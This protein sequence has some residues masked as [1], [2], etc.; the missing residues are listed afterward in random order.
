MATRKRTGAEYDAPYFARAAAGEDIHGEANLITTLLREHFPTR[1]DTAP[2]T[3]QIL[4]A[5]CGTGRTGIELA[6]RGYEVVGVDLDAVMLDQARAKAPNL[7]WHQAD[8]ATV[9]LAER[10]DCIV[11]AGNVM[12][13][14][15][16]G[17]EATVL[18]NLCSQ[19]KP[20]GLVVAGF[21]SRP[22]TWSQL[23]PQRYVDIAA[24][25]GL[26]EVAHW[27]GWGR[28]PIQPQSNYALFVHKVMD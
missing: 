20:G 15:T 13:Y 2:H 5:G 16:P 24:A 25:T 1:A 22:P 26:T 21:E 18:A 8:L 28:E 10:F 4:D 12:I 7:T 19:L 23:T 11:L 3:L 27:A 17:S 9:Q 14:V 6:Q